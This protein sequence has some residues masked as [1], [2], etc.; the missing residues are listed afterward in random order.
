MFT[1]KKSEITKAVKAVEKKLGHRC[2]VTGYTYKRETDP[3]LE[4]SFVEFQFEV[5]DLNGHY[6]A[7]AYLQAFL[8]DRRRS[9]VSYVA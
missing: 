2:E 3:L 7:T 8:P 1:P 9:W 5:C 6:A 4:D